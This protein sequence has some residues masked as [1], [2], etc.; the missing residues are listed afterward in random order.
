MPPSSPT[1]GWVLRGGL[2][3]IGWY[4][5]VLGCLAVG[6]L[7]TADSGCFE[8]CLLPQGPALWLWIG[9][10]ALVVLVLFV[11]PILVLALVRL[12]RRTRSVFAAGSAAALIGLLALALALA[13]LAVGG[14]LL[15]GF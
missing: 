12:H 4:A 1:R 9:V 7:A 11:G 3:A 2:V 14:D 6:D 13:A 10:A 5:L 8:V 15:A